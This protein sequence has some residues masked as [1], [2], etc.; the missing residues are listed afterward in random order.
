MCLNLEEEG[1]LTY[2]Q[3]AVT[4]GPFSRSTTTRMCWHIIANPV[5]GKGGARRWALR[6]ADALRARGDEVALSFT[7]GSS[8]AEIWAQEAAASGVDGVVACGGDGTVHQ[9]INGLMRG[10]S[11]REPPLLGLVPMGRCNDFALGLE[12]PRRNPSQSIEVIL[13]GSRRTIDLGRAGGRYFSIVSSLGFD[14]EV[15]AYVDEGRHPGFLKGTIA[16]L[17]AALVKIFRY[18][19][20]TVSLKGDF[21][22][23]QGPIFL[24]ATGNAPYYG[25][26]MKILP[27]ADMT[28][29][30]LDLCLIKSVRRVEV[31]L[32]LP[33]VFEG[34]HRTHSSVSMHRVRRLEIDAPEPLWLWADGER[35]VQLPATIEV[36]PSCLSVLAPGDSGTLPKSV[37][38]ETSHDRAGRR[39]SQ[40]SS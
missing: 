4:G 1:L 34:G 9:A 7:E 15:S 27:Q 32:M 5:A 23:Y 29:G 36:V 25:G 13:A 20:V 12:I 14:A 35:M 6:L 19:D 40:C 2:E 28:D 30:W 8:S 33:R 26:G 10:S 11:N 39:K 38:L 24:A 31:V 3:T 18:R 22:V 21:G 17:Y 16:Y 37:T